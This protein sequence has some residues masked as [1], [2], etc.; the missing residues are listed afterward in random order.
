MQ[1]DIGFLLNLSNELK[2]RLDAAESNIS[3]NSET[4][5]ELDNRLGTAESSITTLQGDMTG[6]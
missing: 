5:S 4:N 2:E 3:A 1:R 6:M